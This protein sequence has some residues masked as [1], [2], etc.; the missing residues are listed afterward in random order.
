[1]QKR[2]KRQVFEVTINKAHPPS[3]TEITIKFK[4]SS[5]KSVIEKYDALK[6]STSKTPVGFNQV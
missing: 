2:K 4:S 1:M 5:L 6:G 3:S